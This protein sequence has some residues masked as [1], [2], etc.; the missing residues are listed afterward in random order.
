MIPPLGFFFWNDHNLLQQKE[1]TL[2]IVYY[3]PLPFFGQN[4]L[5]SSR[6]TYETP[7]NRHLI[8]WLGQMSKRPWTTLCLNISIPFSAKSHT[9]RIRR[10]KKS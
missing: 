2:N 3:F 5:I 8:S 10:K 1:K 4:L 9:Q 6:S 7:K